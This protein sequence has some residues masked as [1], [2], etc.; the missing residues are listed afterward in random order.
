MSP[1][2]RYPELE[3]LVARDPEDEVAYLAWAP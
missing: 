2:R 3:A 1:A